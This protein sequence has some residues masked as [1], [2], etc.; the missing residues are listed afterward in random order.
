MNQL[1]GSIMNEPLGS[2]MNDKTHCKSKL[3]ELEIKSPDF[4]QRYIY[5]YVQQII[6]IKNSQMIRVRM[7]V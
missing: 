6:E 7:N 2:I 1:Y 5:N 4:K 3:L